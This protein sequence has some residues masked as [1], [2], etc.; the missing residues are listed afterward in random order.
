MNDTLTTDSKGKQWKDRCLENIE[1]AGSFEIYKIIS[2]RNE[3]ENNLMNFFFPPAI[4]VVV[5]VGVR[6]VFRTK[7]SSNS[8]LKSEGMF[9]LDD[10]VLQLVVNL[11]IFELF[12]VSCLE[13]PNIGS[14]SDNTD[15]VLGCI[16]LLL[17]LSFIW[18]SRCNKYN[19]RA[20]FL[21]KSNSLSSYR[22]GCCQI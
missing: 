5:V 15:D 9:L 11:T 3:V 12:S 14:L 4:I 21:Q 8:T 20:R 17:I 19:R 13:Y 7:I 18:F 6:V 16:I 22:F 10:H 1:L 2:R